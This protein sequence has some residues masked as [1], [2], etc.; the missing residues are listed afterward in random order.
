M[1]TLAN[2]NRAPAPIVL[3]YEGKVPEQ[4][5]LQTP[6]GVI[7]AISSKHSDGFINSILFGDNLPILAK[8][9]EE[10]AG[11]IDLIYIDPPFAT[12][13]DF[14]DLDGVVHYED[15]RKNAEF[16][17]W[18]RHRLILLRELLSSR[19]T[20]Y[21][22]IDD[23]IGHHVK[24]LMDD[25]FMPENFMGDIA[26]VKC[27]PKNFS[28][29][30]YGN[31]KDAIY[32]Y[33]KR[34]GHHIWHD[35][36]TPL[37]EADIVRQYPLVGEDGRRY[38][39]NPLHAP[40]VTANGPTGQPWRGLT[41]PRGRHWRYAPSVLEELD[42]RGLIEW[43]ATGNPRKKIYPEDNPGK[44]AQDVWLDYKDKG[45]R[46]TSYPTE[47]NHQMLEMIIR[48][49]SDP[50]SIVLDCF[51]GSGSTLFTAHK[52]GR[53]FIAIDLGDESYQTMQDNFDERG[54]VYNVYQMQDDIAEEAA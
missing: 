54:M 47:K 13:R 45:T 26:R 33:A 39:T 21:L 20:I 6:A 17:E 40:G 43:S 42:Q 49:S 38:A 53:R 7:D 37:T 9:V 25:I 50:D 23:R 34:I 11:K 4:D 48:N 24:L 31:V 19:G 32:I 15:R 2:F 12:G 30:A 52:L 29:K 22:H 10:F 46:Y 27:N 8:L 41:P 35:V 1:T 36:R 16:L 51:A 28:R 44:K 14:A 3:A 5:V 18:L